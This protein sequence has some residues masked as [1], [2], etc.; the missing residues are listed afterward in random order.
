MYLDDHEKAGAD[1]AATVSPAVESEG[2]LPDLFKRDLRHWLWALRRHWLWLVV[3]ALG[4]A[5]L[6]FSVRILTTSKQYESSC[7]LVRQNLP[8]LRDSGTPIYSPAQMSVIFNMIR[9]R[10][11][12][13]ETIRRL[14][15]SWSFRQ[16]FNA[17]EVRPAEK[18]S[19]YFFLTARTGDPNLSAELANMHSLVFLDIYKAFITKSLND[20]LER[21]SDN[22]DILKEELNERQLRQNR[23]L[24]EHNLNSF[25]IEL[26]AL[27]QRIIME[28]ER[29]LNGGTQVEALRSRLAGL[30]AEISQVP[31]KVPVYTERST[32]QDQRLTNMRIELIE[33]KQRYTE[34]NPIVI[35]KI[36]M[37]KELEKEMAHASEGITKE[38]IGRNPEYSTLQTEIIKT[39]AEL[40]AAQSR[41]EKFSEN[42]V[43]Q[44][45]RQETLNQLAPQFQLLEEQISQKKNLINRQEGIRK[46]LEMY[47]E[48]SLTDISIQEKA[49]PSNRSISRKIPLFAG[50]GF[51][52]GLGVAMACA[53]GREAVNL[54]VRT[55]VDVEK[56]LHLSPLGVI[57]RLTP[58][59]RADFYSALQGTVG[60]ATARLTGLPKPVLVAVAPCH[61]EDLDN[62]V[63]SEI[64]GIT[65]VRDIRMLVIKS[66]PEDAP[67]SV[68]PRLINDFLYGLSDELPD[69]GAAG[70]L[71]FKLDD[72]AFLAQPSEARFA[73]LCSR[74]AGFD[75][76]VW[77][78]FDYGLHPQLCVD[79]CASAAL[80]VIPMH[81]A[82]SSKLEIFRMLRHMRSCGVKN[83]CGVLFGMENVF[84]DRVI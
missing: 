40:S 70:E 67:V 23:L 45:A 60:N 17:L 52:L 7:A 66:V 36:E 53:L 61:R 27:G 3:G 58:E 50:I 1:P 78:L 75:V 18:N 69:P 21:S 11:C 63:F 79:I 74:A 6:F 47:L 25:S 30:E 59:H 32:T 20:I 16:L 5:V 19:N 46:E 14:N 77:E 51:I 26:A 34:D 4:G 38:V 41:Y 9:G 44:R 72:M 22:L 65:A 71:Y 35:K 10:S 62:E 64:T 56:A 43:M 31:E 24:K 33:L 81:A 84:Y 82:L 76:V 39:R 55:S 80:T 12:L 83:L 29:L 57:P 15:L 73:E 28:E 2:S 68:S 8:E 42:L 54:S 49:I 37:I 13:E 48:R